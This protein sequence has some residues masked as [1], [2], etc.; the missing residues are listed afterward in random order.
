ME[1]TLLLQSEG[2]RLQIKQV[3]RGAIEIA[4]ISNGQSNLQKSRQKI[5]KHKE[6]EYSIIESVS[7]L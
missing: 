2:R 1:R 4:F 3:L 5:M 6:N 7:P